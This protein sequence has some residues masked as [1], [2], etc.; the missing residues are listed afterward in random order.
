R[1]VFTPHIGSAVA[2]VRV[3]I[4]HRA[5]SNILAALSGRRPQDAVNEVGADMAVGS[6]LG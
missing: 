2:R 5:A 3:E 1:T 4:E 6:T